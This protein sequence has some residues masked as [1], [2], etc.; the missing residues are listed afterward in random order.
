MISVLAKL[1]RDEG[2][3]KGNPS[4]ICGFWKT[5]YYPQKWSDY[6]SQRSGP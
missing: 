2:A 1:K 4:G 5:R 3:A 6:Q